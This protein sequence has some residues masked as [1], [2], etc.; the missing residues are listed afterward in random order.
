MKKII[1]LLIIGLA[2]SCSKKAEQETNAVKSDSVNL[3]TVGG[4]TDANGCKTAAGY[5]W[6]KLKEECVRVFEVGVMVPP[7][8]KN[9]MAAFVIFKKEANKAEIFLV[10]EPSSIILERDGTNYLNGEWK[11]AE[12][13]HGKFILSKGGE[14]LYKQK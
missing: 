14:I 2:V 12:S 3:K 6:S 8:D 1:A 13:P 10:T 11:L 5:T 7:V 9:T 4:D